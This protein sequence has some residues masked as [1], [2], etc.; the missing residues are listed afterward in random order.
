MIAGLFVKD[1][2]LGSMCISLLEPPLYVG[3]MLHAPCYNHKISGHRTEECSCCS[4][5]T[6]DDLILMKAKWSLFGAD[7]PNEKHALFSQVQEHLEVF[8]SMHN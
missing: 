1:A 2:C 4:V 8:P 7:R 3:R 6:S 5:A